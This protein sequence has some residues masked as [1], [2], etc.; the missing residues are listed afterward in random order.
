MKFRRWSAGALLLL[1]LPVQPVLAASATPLTSQNMTVSPTQINPELAPGS[2]SQGQVSVINDGDKGY[3]FTVSATPY[4]VTGEDYDQSFQIIPGAINAATWFTVPKQTYHL[5]PHQSQVVP[6]TLT[7][8]AGT[9]GGG[10]YAT[11]FYQ[12]SPKPSDSSG[13]QRQQRIGVVAYVRVKGDLVEKGSLASFDVDTF[14]PGN[15]VAAILR[16]KNDGNVHYSAEIQLRVTD[17]FGGQKAKV[18]VTR[19][20]LPG[21]IRRFDL[22]W[23]KSPPLGIFR[24][25]GNVSMLGRNEVLPQHYILVLS[26]VAFFVLLGLFCLVA[27]SGLWWW[28]GRQL[29]R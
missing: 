15:P 14:Q 9:Q 23:D 10:Y 2:M 6:Y 8:P 18:Q 25:G 27:L 29:G 13:V 7:V 17:I 22:H 24:V 28:R 11:L 26:P 16:L 12:T 19:E 4:H 21:T 20:V 5:E 1:M 3:D